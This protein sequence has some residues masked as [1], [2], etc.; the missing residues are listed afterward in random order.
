M[1]HA[2]KIRDCAG[3]GLQA[4]PGGA[5]RLR[6]DERDFM[7]GSVKRLQGLSGE[8]RGTREYETQAEA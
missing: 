2:R 8:R 1:E 6:E 4:P 7:P 3:L 5:I